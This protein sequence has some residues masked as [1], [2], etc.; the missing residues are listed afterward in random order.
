MHLV[1]EWTRLISCSSALCGQNC[2][3]LITSKRLEE[4]RAAAGG[5][6]L[7]GEESRGDFAHRHKCERD[8]V[9]YKQKETKTQCCHLT[10]DVNI[11]CNS[12][13]CSSQ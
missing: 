6:G 11:Y 10:K 9:R 1:P 7:S 2:S 5:G 4:D 3:S 12:G 13:A 8:A